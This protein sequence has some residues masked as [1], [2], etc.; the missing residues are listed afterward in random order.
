[1]SLVS[2]D[3]GKINSSISKINDTLHNVIDELDKKEDK[4]NYTKKYFNDNS[5]K[6]V[7]AY[8]NSIAYLNDPAGHKGM[9]ALYGNAFSDEE[10]FVGVGE[11]GPGDTNW[12]KDIIIGWASNSKIIPGIILAK[13]LE[14]GLIDILDPVSKYIPDCSGNANYITG[15]K[16]QPDSIDTKIVSSNPLTWV[17]TYGTF[18]LNTITIGH[19]IQ[20]GVGIPYSNYLHAS[21]AYGYLYNNASSSNRSTIMTKA[22]S[23]DPDKILAQ[24]MMYQYTLFNKACREGTYNDVQIKNVQGLSYKW[25]DSVINALL[26]AKKNS[27]D[28]GFIPLSY[29]T[30]VYYNG[31]SPFNANGYMSS[32]APALDLLTICLD[33]VAKNANNPSYNSFHTYGRKKIIEPLGMTL[34]QFKGVEP[35]LNGKYISMAFARDANIASYDSSGNLTEASYYCDPKY[36]KDGKIGTVQWCSLYP[37]DGMSNLNRLFYDQ[38]DP[39]DVCPGNTCLISSIGDLAKIYK[40]VIKKGVSDNGVRVLNELSIKWLLSPKVNPLVNLY[41]IYPIA[42]DTDATSMCAGIAK[43]N[44]DICSSA[45]NYTSGSMYLWGGSQGTYGIFDIETGHYVL[46]GAAENSFGYI[47]NAYRTYDNAIRVLVN[48][49]KP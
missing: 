48:A 9:F 10:D 17:P 16:V 36:I 23:N 24:A 25:K 30:G 22:L 12:S 47:K 39:T 3:I 40:M 35:K 28:V 32:Y 31:L 1:M 29:R 14:E 20:F 19:L 5:K 26:A 8:I 11:V 27:T 2:Q 13:M 44:T 38:Y 42:T 46:M 7:T 21:T 18:N 33:V 45:T 15:M 41:G 4:P 37:N 49:L 43:I 6:N 34:S